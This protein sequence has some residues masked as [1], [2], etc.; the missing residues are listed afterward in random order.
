ME[1]ALP[2]SRNTLA[3]LLIMIGGTIKNSYRVSSLFSTPEQLIKMEAAAKEMYFASNRMIR[4]Q[5]INA[6]VEEITGLRIV[7]ESDMFEK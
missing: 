7:I 6:L 4:D 3:V 2:I 5:N 1:F